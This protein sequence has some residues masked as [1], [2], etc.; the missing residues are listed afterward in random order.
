MV[1]TIVNTMPYKDMLCHSI[2]VSAGGNTSLIAQ[3]LSELLIQYLHHVTSLNEWCD[4][5]HKNRGPNL[6]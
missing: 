6:F 2:V 4:L 1:N 3:S 5:Q